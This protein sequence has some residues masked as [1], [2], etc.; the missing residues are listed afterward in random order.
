MNQTIETRKD[1]FN[2]SEASKVLKLH[3][4]TV[5]NMIDDGRIKVELVGKRNMI[6]SS[7]IARIKN[8][9]TEQNS[10]LIELDMKIAI[11][12]DEL[13]ALLDERKNFGKLSKEDFL[14]GLKS[15]QLEG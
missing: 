9:S 14:I 12:M 3:R 4:N 5:S 15:L 1:F 11:K 8:G 2:M 13:Q 10:D 6:H 7:E